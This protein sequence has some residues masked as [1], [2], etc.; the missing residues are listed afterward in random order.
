MP[1]NRA[2]NNLEALVTRRGEIAHQVTAGAAV[3]RN[4]VESSLELIYQ[5]GAVASNVVRNF[6][7]E[8]TGNDPWVEI[9]RFRGA[10]V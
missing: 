4:Y 7:I 3:R 9:V 10:A 1:N 2:V 8:R 5:L 6:L